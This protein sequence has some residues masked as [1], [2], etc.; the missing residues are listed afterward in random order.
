MSSGALLGFSLLCFWDDSGI[1]AALIPA[2]IAHELGH[3]SV[4]VILKSRLLGLNL[5]LSGF[6]MEYTRFPGV[7]GEIAV[8]AAGPLSGIVYAFAAACAGKNSGSEF[9]LCSAGI[10]LL[11]S[12]FNLLPAPMLDGGQLLKSLFGTGFAEAAGYITGAMVAAG[13]IYTVFCGYGA[14]VLMAGCCILIGTCKYGKH[15]II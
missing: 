11:L 4:L 9:L 14:A 13:G 10:S 1:W 5:D 7:M 6:R 8:L 3:A 15:S 2:V 12:L